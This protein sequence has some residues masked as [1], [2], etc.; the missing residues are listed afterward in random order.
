MNPVTQTLL[1]FLVF[2][3]LVMP[4]TAMADGMATGRARII[5][6]DT[7]ELAGTRIRLEGIDAPERSQ[8]C[9]DALE[10]PY[11]CGA[12]AVRALVELTRGQT[13]T[14]EPHGKD[15]YG[16]T[17]GICRLASGLDVNA[18]LVRQG[19]AVAFRRYSDRYIGEE[20]AARASKTGLWAG[21]FEHPGCYRAHR[22]GD[23]CQDLLPRAD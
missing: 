11:D 15:K 2:G 5:D 23:E 18:E 8:Q 14:C 22:R 9:Q 17:L 13:V 1:I 7:L 21:T 6:G 12:T 16:R 4:M 3:W 19:R 20:D 10:Q